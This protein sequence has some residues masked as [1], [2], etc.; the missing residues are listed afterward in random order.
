VICARGGDDTIQSGPARDF[1]W[2]GPGNDRVASRSGNDFVTDGLGSDTFQLGDGNDVMR[3]SKGGAD[4]YFGGDGGDQL[5]MLT[6]RRASHP[7]TVNLSTGQVEG[8]AIGSD[9]VRAFEHAMGT[10]HD[11]TLIGNASRNILAGR[12]GD[13]HIEGRD[14]ND[15][16][17]GLGGSD[18][19]DGGIG[20]DECLNGE[21]ILNCET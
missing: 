17:W 4:A 5:T 16:L 2:D 7:V 12:L 6:P 11:D 21:T 3:I 8:D 1:V 19:L 18:F 9:S 15:Q 20:T 13:D 14:G 10:R